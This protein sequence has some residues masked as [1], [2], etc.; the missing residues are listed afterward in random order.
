MANNKIIYGNEVLI[1]LTG[2]TVDPQHL[3]K[4]FTAHDKSG[5][6]ITG[7]N[8]FD[9][10]TSDATVSAGEIL[11]GKTA[12][13]RGAKVTGSMP[14]R[15]DASGV[16][17]TKNQE[18]AIQSGYH[19]GSGKVKIDDTEKAKIIAGNIKAGVQILGVEGTYGGEEI[20]VQTKSATPY[21]NKEQTIL[22]DS[23]FDY[24]SQVTVA[25]IAYEESDNSAG[26]KTITIGTVSP[27]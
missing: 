24:L 27:N 1:D 4:G 11:E 3:A 20:K 22:P 18:Y 17:S 9:S 12:Y 2:D 6:I 25:K 19:D 16:I 14:D 15:G 26:G 7:E 10:D 21:T 5:E 23:G 8:T 13:V